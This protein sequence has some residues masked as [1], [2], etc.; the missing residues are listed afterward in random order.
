VCSDVGGMKAV[1]KG[2]GVVVAPERPADLRAAL[3]RLTADARA[4]TTLGHAGRTRMAREFSIAA[5][6]VA[7]ATAYDEAVEGHGATTH[8]P[9]GDSGRRATARGRLR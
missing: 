6:G 2:C 5:M 1:V 8:R 9:T 4:R 3:R 7:L